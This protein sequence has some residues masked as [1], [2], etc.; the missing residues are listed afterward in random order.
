V[1]VCKERMGLSSGFLAAI[2]DALRRRRPWSC[3]L[4]SCI[5]VWVCAGM[6]WLHMAS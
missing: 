4:Y 6:H 5:R 2:A 1:W 3:S